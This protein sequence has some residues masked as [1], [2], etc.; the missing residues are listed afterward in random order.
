MVNLH[1][2]MNLKLVNSWLSVSAEWH[3]SLR[4]SDIDMHNSCASGA[5]QTD[6]VYL[7][8][9]LWAWY[10]HHDILASLNFSLCV[11]CRR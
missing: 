10:V 4:C 1:G 5:A 2:Y 8:V 11:W 9:V 6:N 7:F 3:N